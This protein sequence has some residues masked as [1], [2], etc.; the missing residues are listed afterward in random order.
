MRGM[1]LLVVGLLLAAS[2]SAVA[3]PLP[4]AIFTTDNGSQLVNGN[5]YPSKDAV[6][7]NGGPMRPGAAG[8]PDG[9]YY[10]QVTEPGGAVLG[11]SLGTA[12]ETPILVVYGEFAACYQLSAILRDPADNSM[13][14][15]DTGN[16]GGEYKVW[17]S[18]LS[19][20]DPNS[21]KTD[22]FK[23]KADVPAFGTLS[24]KSF[25]DA[26]T[27]GAWD[28]NEAGLPGWQLL[29]VDGTVTSY[30]EIATLFSYSRV[31]GDNGAI[32]EQVPPGHYTIIEYLPVPT[33]ESPAKWVPTTAVVG[34]ASVTVNGTASVAFG[35]VYLGAGGGRTLGFW[36]NKNGQSY[37]GAD[38]LFLLRWLNLANANGS[39]FDPM[40]SSALRTWLL[41]GKAVNM[42]NMLSVQ[43]AAMKLNVNNGFVADTALVY[44][45]H[46][47]GAN[48]AGFT[49]IGTLMQ[50]ANNSLAAYRITLTDNAQR[51]NQ[52]YLK[53]ALDAAN[54]N[55]IFVQPAPCPLFGVWQLPGS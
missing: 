51:S 16:A 54:N 19:T 33:P 39:V 41:N 21:S 11:T 7:L 53:N 38:D 37:V 10:V 44:A 48:A 9:E 14:Y 46:V 30:D 12:D 47:P 2:V 36:S 24:M 43:L 15:A 25:Y 17:V 4:G 52:E 49:S 55:L 50:T 29:I 28:P 32:C 22:N 6:Y 31:T 40:I 45:P 20:F 42:A 1:Y 3:A 5:I 26:D 27:D 35:N 34:Y 13:G 8:L 18:P 23:V